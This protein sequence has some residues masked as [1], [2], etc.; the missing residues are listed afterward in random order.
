MIRS[1][2]G[3]RQ[4]LQ[5]AVSGTWTS[6]SNTI[7]MSRPC[8]SRCFA[9]KRPSSG[10]GAKPDKGEDKSLLKSISERPEDDDV[11]VIPPELR[12]KTKLVKDLIPEEKRIV[13][14]LA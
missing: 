10:L 11:Y 3:C 2:L 9:R 8:I 14:A 12:A 4:F 1:I 6:L 5:P 7:G 13:V